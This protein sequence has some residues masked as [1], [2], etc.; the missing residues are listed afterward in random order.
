MLSAMQCAAVQNKNVLSTFRLIPVSVRGLWEAFHHNT[1][2][3]VYCLK[4]VGADTVA[5]VFTEIQRGER[6]AALR[7]VMIIDNISFLPH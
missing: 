4:G 6:V 1:S 5:L 3:T 7:L 2:A